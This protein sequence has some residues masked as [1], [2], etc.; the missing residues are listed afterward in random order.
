MDLWFGFSTR[1]ERKRAEAIG[2]TDQIRT[3]ATSVL[4]DWGY[5]QYAVPDQLLIA[6]TSE[7]EIEAGGGEFAYFRSP[8][9]DAL[10]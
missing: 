9:M 5:P 7:E 1:A 8:D 4:V 6:F 3:I 2:V 10:N